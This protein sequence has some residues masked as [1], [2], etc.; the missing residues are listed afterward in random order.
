VAGSQYVLQHG[1][2]GLDI[3][4]DFGNYAECTERNYGSPEE[5]AV[6]FTGE[7]HQVAGCGNDFQRRRGGDAS[8]FR[9]GADSD[10]RRGGKSPDASHGF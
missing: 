6:G 9:G 2:S 4:R 10:W 3:E 8:S 7:F 5:F 1:V